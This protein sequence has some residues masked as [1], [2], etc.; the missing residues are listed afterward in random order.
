MKNVY[1]II[2]KIIIGFLLLVIFL[3]IL[4]IATFFVLNHTG[5]I[6]TVGLWFMNRNLVGEMRFDSLHFDFAEFPVIEVSASNGLLLSDTLTFPSDTLAAFRYLK[7]QINPFKVFTDNLIDIPYVYLIKPQAA[8]ILNEH[9]RPGWAI[10]RFKKQTSPIEGILP[11]KRP[12]IKLDIQHVEI[13]DNPRFYYRNYHTGMEIRANASDLFLIGHIAIDYKKIDADLFHLRNLNYRMTIPKAATLID[14]RSDS[15]YIRKHVQQKLGN[16]QFHLVTDRDTIFVKGNPLMLDNR[17]EVHGRIGIGYD[18]QLLQLYDTRFQLDTTT[19]WMRGGFHKIPNE[20]AMNT[21]LQ[22]QLSTPL[23]SRSI[24]DLVPVRN[25][26]PSQLNLQMPLVVT[27]NLKGVFSPSKKIYPDLFARLQVGPG[28]ICYR[29]IPPFRNVKAVLRL[30]YLTG[31]KY[32]EFFIDSLGVKIA[33]TAVSLSASVQNFITNPFLEA[34]IEYQAHFP[35]FSLLMPE[36]G[37]LAGRS[38]GEIIFSS[39]LRP[40]LK[41]QLDDLRV[42]S[43]IALDSIDYKLKDG[44]LITVNSGMFLVDL[45]P[46]KIS[47]MP[48]RVDVK[49]DTVVIV[50]DSLNMVVGNIQGSLDGDRDAVATV[51][52]LEGQM[53]LNKIEVTQIANKKLQLGALTTQ[54]SALFDSFPKLPDS[55]KIQAALHRVKGTVDSA[56]IYMRNMGFFIDFA[57]KNF[58]PSHS[59]DSLGKLSEW[60]LNKF[61]FTGGV[62]ITQSI[63]QT[64][65]LP[66]YNELDSMA[67]VFNQDLIQIPNLTCRSGLSA[68]NLEAEVKNWRNYLLKDS[69]LTAA[70]T[71]TADSLNLTQLIPALTKGIFYLHKRKGSGVDSLINRL[72]PPQLIPPKDSRIRT[73]ERMVDIPDNLNIL[74]NVDAQNVLYDRV[75]FDESHGKILVTNRSAFVHN[76]FVDSNLGNL[77]VGASYQPADTTYAHTSLSFKLDKLD[78]DRLLA[79]FPDLRKVIPMLQTLEG[80]VGCS[81]SASAELD[82]TLYIQMPTL[83]GNAEIHGRNLSVDKDKILPSFVGWLL[84]GKNKKIVLDSIGVKLAMKE[85]I[86]SVY[87]FVIDI[88]RYRIL[89][90]G[91]QDVNENFF[92]HFSLLKWL[93]PFKVGFNIYRQDKKLHFRLACPRLKDMNTAA[94]ILAV[95]PAR[96]YPSANVSDSIGAGMK[97]QQSVFMKYSGYYDSIQQNESQ[98]IS[99]KQTDAIWLQL[100]SLR[101]KQIRLQK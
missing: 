100:D 68:L 66:L 7:A 30:N 9:G 5:S 41:K 8:V 44:S 61:D 37:Q 76:I 36:M 77:D 99:K 98:E 15:I 64:P 58:S 49:L 101:Q 69:M 90:N 33:Q 86:L 32:G 13:Y 97:Q 45:P 52:K 39:P 73:K 25:H 24:H 71:I 88:N 80:Y 2:L 14:T 75:R 10:W 26:F 27:V 51:K 54:F 3:V 83:Q 91:V 1:K 12:A 79:L 89:A 93:L 35:D 20:K 31:S 11:R 18:Y 17:F 34:Q 16:Y 38:N 50:T 29:Q 70:V 28:Q 94:R 96:F 82:S 57:Q 42:Y 53:Q 55:L 72:T 6:N 40:L 85:N 4:P 43:K 46:F 48:L 92:Y 81:I 22:V 62:R 67:V 84:F 78:V 56:G 47:K 19:L 60:L 87:P 95:D 65:V 59:K 21:D 74:L 23:L 63:I